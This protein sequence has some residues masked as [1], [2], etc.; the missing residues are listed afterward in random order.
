MNIF[1]SFNKAY[2]KGFTECDDSVYIAECDDYDYDDEYET[3]DVIEESNRPIKKSSKDSIQSTSTFSSTPRKS[4]KSRKQIRKE[5]ANI[6]LDRLTGVS[7]SKPVD[8]KNKAINESCSGLNKNKK[9]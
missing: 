1:E 6:A 5:K 2:D 3:V 4:R 7:S 9:A 8:S